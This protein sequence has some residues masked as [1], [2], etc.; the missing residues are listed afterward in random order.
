MILAHRRRIK[1]PLDSSYITSRSQV[2]FQRDD[3]TSRL[4]F[5]CGP[6]LKENVSWTNVFMNILF[7]DDSTY[8]YLFWVHVATG[9][10]QEHSSP[11]IV[12]STVKNVK[13]ELHINEHCSQ[14]MEVHL[15]FSFTMWLTQHTTDSLYTDHWTHEF[16]SPLWWI[17]FFL[18]AVTAGLP[19]ST[20]HQN[21]SLLQPFPSCHHRLLISGA[22]S[23]LLW[24]W[25][26]C[27]ISS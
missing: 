16:E 12:W 27:H 2:S 19:I 3:I 6:S 23:F 9:K 15:K 11:G 18:A 22:P 7:F 5:K 4:F 1:D 26:T 10:M 17:F 25:G 13:T 8:T 24:W 14:Q 21:Y 20:P